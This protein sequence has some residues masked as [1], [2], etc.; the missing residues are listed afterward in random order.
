MSEEQ[1]VFRHP[2]LTWDEWVVLDHLLRG[3][4]GH[5]SVRSFGLPGV[6]WVMTHRRS[7]RQKYGCPDIPTVVALVR[8]HGAPIAPPRNWT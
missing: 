4:S 6:G 8:R 5:E 7:L 2:C 1:P 3:I